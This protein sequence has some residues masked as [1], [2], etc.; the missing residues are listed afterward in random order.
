[1]IPRKKD[2]EKSA[3]L[4]KLYWRAGDAQE[5]LDLWRRS[6]MTLAGF[7][8]AHGVKCNR[9]ARWRAR[10]TADD[11]VIPGFHRIRIV[12]SPAMRGTDGDG[13]EIIVRGSRRVVV[14]PGFDGDLLAEV[15]RVLEA[16][17]C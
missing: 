3:V 7:A 11:A 10:L 12:E 2:P 8:R 15:M 6:G 14:R 16:L 13:I 4:Q 1:M 17:P 9:L 5:I